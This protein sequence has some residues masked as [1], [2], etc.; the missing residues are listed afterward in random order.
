MAG[1][2]LSGVAAGA[3][4]LA[5]LT[6][7]ALQ[8]QAIRGKL[9]ERGT[10]APING[11][12]VTLV[13]ASG[14]DAD[15]VLTDSLGAFV[16]VAPAPGT[17]RLRADQIG[18]RS[19]VS[20][21]LRL[22][23]G[24]TLSYRME[25]AIEPIALRGISVKGAQRCEMR[26]A[27]GQATQLL[28]DEARKALRIASFTEHAGAVMLRLRTYDVQLDP[29]RMEPERAETHVREGFFTHSPFVSAPA[30]DLAKNGYV[31]TVEDNYIDYF[32]PDADVLLS[33]AFLDAH[34]FQ[35]QVD[36]AP[37]AGLIGLAFEPVTHAAPDVAGVLWIERSTGELRSLVFHYT[38]LPFRGS[39]KDSQA[40]GYLAFQ[41]MRNG[42]W[43]VRKWWI[44]MPQLGAR[45]LRLNT[46]VHRDVTVI[47]V[48]ET[49]GEVLQASGG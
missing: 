37:A 28:W 35:V 6:G 24:A 9:V 15:G 31:R 48:H 42:A 49:G 41:H 13:T 14:G 10:G 27:D 43:I 17:Y 11:A 38:D 1:T 3:T 36:D 19:T 2:R 33:D 20:E 23:A 45:V 30:E 26:P 4:L 39:I 5:L 25:A 7:S 16:L 12:F 34:C 22:D 40:G 46:Q 44:R 21:P 8:A 47:S 32:A 18:H 29:D